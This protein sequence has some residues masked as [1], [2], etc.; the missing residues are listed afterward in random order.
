[1]LVGSH[2]GCGE[3]EVVVE[4]SVHEARQGTGAG[5]GPKWRRRSFPRSS[6]SRAG[7]PS[8]SGLLPFDPG[9]GS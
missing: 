8:V 3:G 4:R 9:P 7:G 2:T 6:V 1:M 5:L